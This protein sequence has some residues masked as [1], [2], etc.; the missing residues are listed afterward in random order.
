MGPP[1]CVSKGWRVL[2]HLLSGLLLPSFFH[3]GSFSYKI[4]ETGILG[5]FISFVSGRHRCSVGDNINNGGGRG[6]L[7][8]AEEKVCLANG[9]R[10]ILS[11]GH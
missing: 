5:I 11:M 8:S 7:A 4:E 10:T 1:V 3:M 9:A 6:A 2:V